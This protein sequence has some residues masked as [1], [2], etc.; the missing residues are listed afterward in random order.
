M[1]VMNTTRRPKE[2]LLDGLDHKLIALLRADGRVAISR[3]ATELGVSRGTAQNRF[4]RLV[5]SGAILGFTVRVMD[6]SDDS[7]IR[8]IMMI[9]VVGKSTNQVIRELR[10]LPELEKLHSTNGNWDLVAE[11]RAPSLRSFDR[12]LRIVREIDGVL[13]SESSLLLSSV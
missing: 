13:N 10:G 3:I 6:E 11:L 7:S 5:D 8:A 4:D 2:V 12:I 9:E 1:D